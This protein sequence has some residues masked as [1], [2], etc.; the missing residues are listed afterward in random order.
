MSKVRSRNSVLTEAQRNELVVEDFIY[1]ILKSSED[2]PDY[3][4][5]VVLSSESQRNFFKKII[6]ETGRGTQYNFID[7]E[8]SH[9]VAACNSIIINPSAEFIDQ[10]KEIARIFLNQHSGKTADGVLIIAR[11]TISA[12]TQRQSLIALIKLDYSTVLRQ[13]RDAKQSTKVRLEEII[14]AL[15]EQAASVQKRA[16]IQLDNTFSWDVL[17]VE[18]KKSGAVL[19]TEDAITDYF[20]RF[21]GVRLK[22]NDSA[23]TKQVVVA[24]HKWAKQ[25]DGDLGGKTPADIR[26][27]VISL[28][29]AYSEAE[30]SFEEI[31][32][33]I[34]R[35]SDAAE[36]EKMSSSFD[37]Y[38]DETGLGGI[39]FSPKSGSIPKKDRKGEW[40][41]DAGIKVIWE[42]ERNPNILDKKKQAD[43]SFIITIKASTIDERE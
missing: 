1:H 29:D 31:K 43:G 26:H 7:K 17:A 34:C 33:Q 35:H 13:Q 40:I 4:D 32:N 6:A 14:E 9:L 24:C 38:M 18:R 25:Y 20:K 8:N 27:S 41:T 36:A 28:L 2:E 39:V 21:L 12:N 22:Q 42:G 15:S 16:L 3:L 10:S 23:I 5:E 11:A 30:L 19:D 37:S